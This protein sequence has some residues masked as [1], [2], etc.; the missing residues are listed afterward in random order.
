MWP[1]KLALKRWRKSASSIC[2]ATFSISAS[3]ARLRTAY[4]PSSHRSRSAQQNPDQKIFFF[5]IA[6]REA[7]NSLQPLSSLLHPLQNRPGA[8]IALGGNSRVPGHGGQGQAANQSRHSLRAPSTP[9][10]ED[11]AHFPAAHLTMPASLPSSQPYPLQDIFNL[12]PNLNSTDLASAMSSA[13][14]DQMLVV[15]LATLLRAS[16]ALHNLIN[17]KVGGKRNFS[18]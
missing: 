10:L 7:T 18:N 5:A 8:P 16:I 11:H 14:S 1:A 6:A 17:N 4:S 3:A 9:G 15:Y 2:F 12:L 13:T